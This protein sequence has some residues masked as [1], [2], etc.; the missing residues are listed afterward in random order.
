MQ[1]LS[2]LTALGGGG[3]AG[4]AGAPRGAGGGMGSWLVDAPSELSVTREHFAAAAA[5][6]G[7]SLVRGAEADVKPVRYGRPR[8]TM[9]QSLIPHL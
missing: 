2:D 3:T 6:V 9:A 8:L 7:P 4:D 1:A 5:K